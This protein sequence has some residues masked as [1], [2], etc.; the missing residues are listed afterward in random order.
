MYQK[1]P[2]LNLASIVNVALGKAQ[3]VS[4]SLKCRDTT[5]LI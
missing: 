4:I 1:V 2:D 5:D 3:F